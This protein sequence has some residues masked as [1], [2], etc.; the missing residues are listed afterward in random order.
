VGDVLHCQASPVV[1][2]QVSDINDTHRVRAA[3]EDQGF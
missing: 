1:S 2:S 3:A